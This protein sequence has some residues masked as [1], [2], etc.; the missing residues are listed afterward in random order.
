MSTNLRIYCSPLVVIETVSTSALTCIN[1]GKPG[2][3]GDY[4][5]DIQN[6][7]HNTAAPSAFSLFSVA[8]WGLLF[9][10]H[11]WP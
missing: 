3:D 8:G 9:F 1:P 2:A 7:S 5:H 11:G 4:I 6:I 10:K